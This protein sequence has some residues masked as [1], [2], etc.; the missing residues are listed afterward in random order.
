M[1][2]NYHK[3][4]KKD[5]HLL[6]NSSNQILY[7]SQIQFYQPFFSLYFNIHNTKNSHKCI[8]LKN[9]FIIKNF[10]NLSIINDY[11]SNSFID[12]NIFD[13]KNN[14]LFHKEIF[15][16]CIPLL[17]PYHFIM[18]NY[19]ISIHRNNLLPSNYIYNTYH[20]IN[21]MNNNAYID[22]FLSYIFSN[23]T[24]KNILPSFSQYYGSFNGIKKIYVHDITDDYSNLKN[25]KWFY[26]SIGTLFNLN[27][28]ESNSSNSSNSNSNSSS[29]SNSSLKSKLSS[30]S[31]SSSSTS[32][33][34]SNSSL[35]YKLPS[36]SLS[37]N[38]TDL[39]YSSNSSSLFDDND[40]IIELLNIPCQ[41]IF[42]EKLDDTLENLL[43]D[44]INEI[45][46]NLILS[47][48]FQISF[49]LTYLQK[50]F[51]F[52]HNDLH[53]NNIMYIKTKKEFL[54]YKFNNTYYKIPTYGYLFKIIDF[55]RAIFTFHNK[56]FFND[57]FEK[58]G[59][60]EGQYT[61]P[62]DNLLFNNH[63]PHI[64]GGQKNKNK[65]KDIKQNY[66][67]DLC[68]LAITILD[69]INF[70]KNIDYGNN[71]YFIDFLYNLTI[72]KFNNSLY[73]L[74]DDFDMYINISKYAN[75][76]LPRLIVQDKI[77]NIF[78]INKKKFPKKIYYHL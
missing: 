34:S 54:Y 78:R 50:H 33:S 14:L 1:N 46:I 48:I 31:N 10:N 73:D 2:I 45:N 11:T 32:N 43:S 65:D 29:K 64:K 59:E 42:I 26:T 77:F 63:N 44:N 3:W 17:D 53:I 56:L 12:S 49:A 37:S 36:K 74:N 39:S 5:Y 69:V 71:Q 15:C 20:K 28:Y 8:D 23:L 52:T 41:C 19:N 25:N 9:R 67:F 55:G 27:I 51:Q 58:Y 75:N 22:S 24:E 4:N 72:N 57:N 16:K 76:A 60:A 35:K 61:S 40:Y 21:N 47:C 6:N 30:K 38:S 13:L 68:R 18:N 62:F 70:K 7:L 66:H